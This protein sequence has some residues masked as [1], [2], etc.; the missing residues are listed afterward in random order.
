MSQTKRAY[1]LL[2]KPRSRE[3]RGMKATYTTLREIGKE[4]ADVS[5]QKLHRAITA[6]RE[7]AMVSPWHGEN[8]ELRLT[9]DD[10]LRLKRFLGFIRNGDSL[11]SALSKLE[12]DV[13]RSRVD[14]L[15]NENERLKA[16]VEWK[17]RWWVR[18]LRRMLPRRLMG[19]LTPSVGAAIIK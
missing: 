15:Q 4:T 1:G 14:E 7:A 19:R 3:N 16:L 6:L 12:S 2:G 17:P 18:L 11:K 8:N 13:L 5:Y 9:L 10:G